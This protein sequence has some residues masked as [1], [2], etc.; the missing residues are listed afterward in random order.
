MRSAELVHAGDE[1]DVFRVR[2]ADGG[3]SAL[4][5]PAGRSAG[6]TSCFRATATIGCISTIWDVIT[7]AGPA[8]DRGNRDITDPSWSVVPVDARRRAFLDDEAARIAASDGT[9]NHDVIEIGACARPDT[10]AMTYGLRTTWFDGAPLASLGREAQRAVFPRLL[11]S[12]WRALAT[13]RHGDLAPGNLIVGD[14]HFALIDP[15]A[16]VVRKR[17]QSGASDA[18]TALSFVTNAA[19][20]AILPPFAPPAPD[21]RARL[22]EQW[23][24]TVSSMTRSFSYPPSVRDGGGLCFA[25]HDRPRLAPPHPEGRPL[26]SDWHAVAILYFEI[27]TGRSPY[28]SARERGPAWSGL[29]IIDDWPEGTEE[30]GARLVAEPPPP[31]SSID[32]SVTSDEDALVRDLLDLA[33]DGPDELGARVAAIVG[34]PASP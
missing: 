24:F 27:L 28:P 4:K 32:P 9:W 30:R 11:P 5:V 1:F 14:T 12:L 33:V 21:P 16:M 20:Y 15:G 6:G 34:R 8:S 25:I 19:R 22:A 13:A 10:G 31:A 23:A 3:G 26:P 7:Q 17:G 2:D 18:A 29:R